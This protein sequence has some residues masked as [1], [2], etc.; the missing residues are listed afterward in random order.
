MLLWMSKLL[1]FLS[2]AIII[3]LAE[4]YTA[5]Q[6]FHFEVFVELHSRPRVSFP[7]RDNALISS[8]PHLP[9]ADTTV[10]AAV[11]G[12]SY[13]IS[14]IKY[15]WNNQN[16][17]FPPPHESKTLVAPVGDGCSF[18]FSSELSSFSLWRVTDLSNSC[19]VSDCGLLPCT[20]QC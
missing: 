18:K 15:Q 5:A 9:M 17:N 4:L 1:F 19:D 14:D 2:T 20:R 12:L 7:C 13:E 10:D 16:H 3:R 6:G 8:P 11:T